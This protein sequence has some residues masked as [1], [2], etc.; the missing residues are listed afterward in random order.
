[1]VW[2]HSGSGMGTVP[3]RWRGWGTR[4][5]GVASLG[6]AASPRRQEPDRALR[7]VRDPSWSR[8]FAAALITFL[9]FCCWG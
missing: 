7:W 5:R 9:L 8:T 2:G 6:P 3:G 1:M 4:A